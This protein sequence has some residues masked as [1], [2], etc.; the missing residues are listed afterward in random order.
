MISTTSTLTHFLQNRRFTWDFSQ[1]RSFS[2]HLPTA[3][4]NGTA[5]FNTSETPLWNCKSQWNYDANVSL[6]RNPAPV[7][8]KASPF[9][10]DIPLS[11]KSQCNSSA[12]WH[13]TR[14]WKVT[15]WSSPQRQCHRER[16][17]TLANGCGHENNDRRTQ[18]Y[19]QT[20]KLNENPSLRIRE[21]ILGKEFYGR[22]LST[23]TFLWFGSAQSHDRV[24]FN[25]WPHV[26]FHWGHFVTA[27]RL[28][29]TAALCLAKGPA[30]EHVRLILGPHTWL[31]IESIF[32]LDGGHL[33]PLGPNN[34][35]LPLILILTY[36]SL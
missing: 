4:P 17:R 20:P 18:L 3:K 13:V 21:K 31:S 28:I 27:T 32:V 34:L 19:P 12:H 35:E 5:R 11:C 33:S 25:A 30:V 15:F 8:R 16:I 29:L 1:K 14:P 7:Q 2:S 23:V 6:S 9:L 22:K 26:V 36:F 10:H 24:T